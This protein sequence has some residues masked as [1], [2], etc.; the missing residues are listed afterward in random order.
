MDCFA[1]LAMTA[2]RTRHT[3]LVIARLDRVIQH[4]RDADDESRGR[5]VLDR[6]V[7]PEMTA[8]RNFRRPGFE[9]GPIAADAEFKPPCSPNPFHN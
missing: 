3:L 8:V 5:G 9:P 2:E 4:S 7:K 1:T 6:P